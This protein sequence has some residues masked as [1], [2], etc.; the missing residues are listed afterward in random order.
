MQNFT[1][2]TEG[3]FFHSEIEQPVS[4]CP[5]VLGVMPPSIATWFDPDFPINNKM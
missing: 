5:G 3:G 1:E 4:V 2:M